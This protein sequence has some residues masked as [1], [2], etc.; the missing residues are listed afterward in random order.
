MFHL[1]ILTTLL[2]GCDGAGKE[3]IY[4]KNKN[5]E[6]NFNSILSINGLL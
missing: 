2:I 5:H 6:T 4:F 1:L 3:S